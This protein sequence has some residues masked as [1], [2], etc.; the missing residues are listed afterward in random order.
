MTESKS[1]VLPLHYKAVN[2]AS[3]LGAANY[4]SPPLFG[5]PEIYANDHF[6]RNRQEIRYI[7]NRAS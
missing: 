3:A 2:G 6:L 5:N 4:M 7:L 1:G